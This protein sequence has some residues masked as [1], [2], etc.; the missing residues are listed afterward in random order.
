MRRSRKTK[1]A[2]SSIS[3][4][5]FICQK[6]WVELVWWMDFW[7]LGSTSKHFSLRVC[8][9]YF[10]SVFPRPELNERIL[11]LMCRM[12]YVSQW[13]CI[14]KYCCGAY[15]HNVQEN[16]TTPQLQTC[17]SSAADLITWIWN[18]T[19]QRFLHFC[20]ELISIW[21]SI[22]SSELLKNSWEK[23]CQEKKKICAEMKLQNEGYWPEGVVDREADF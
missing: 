5:S 17:S 18:V 22:L 4:I 9:V 11:E 16:A 10:G 19:A 7:R 13:I 1:K 6:A 2:S 21:D 20:W 8:T 23:P 14:L 3:S 15:L 12:R